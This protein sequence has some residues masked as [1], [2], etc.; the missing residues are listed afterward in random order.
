MDPLTDQVLSGSKMLLIQRSN[1]ISREK[2][3]SFR[4]KESP[5]DLEFQKLTVN[6]LP[7]LNKASSL[8]GLLTVATPVNLSRVIFYA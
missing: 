2:R 4:E 8:Q 1:S 7:P 6:S 5:I 3:R